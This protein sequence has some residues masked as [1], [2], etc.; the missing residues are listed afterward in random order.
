MIA[1]RATKLLRYASRIVQPGEVFHVKLPAHARLFTGIRRAI[2]VDDPAAN[3]SATVEAIEALMVP[4]DF[5]DIYFDAA[6][7]DE[8]PPTIAPYDIGLPD[9][10]PAADA[11][12]TANADDEEPPIEPAPKRRHYR[13]RDMTPE[14][15]S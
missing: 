4:N 13:R 2:V 15:E 3:P 8:S 14:G 12:A 10:P 11:P 1:L 7:R 5:Q 9:L 6:P